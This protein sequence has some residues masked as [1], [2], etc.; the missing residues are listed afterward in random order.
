VDTQ[1][2]DDLQTAISSLTACHEELLSQDLAQWLPQAALAFIGFPLILNI[3]NIN[4]SSPP[5][6][7]AHDDSC[8]SLYRRTSVFIHF[9][10]V[11]CAKYE[12]VDWFGDIVR[13]IANLA[14]LG[15]FTIQR[16]KPSI[17]WKDV[18]ACQPRS[19]LR[20]VMVLDLGLVK[21]RLPRDTDFPVELRGLFSVDLNAP[22]GL[23]GSCCSIHDVP[24]Q[25]VPSND[26]SLDSAQVSFTMPDSCHIDTREIDAT[27]DPS[28]ET[29]TETDPAR[30]HET[31]TLGDECSL[32]QPLMTPLNAFEPTCSDLQSLGLFS[33][34]LGKAS[35]G[36]GT[37]GSDCQIWES[38]LE[39]SRSSVDQAVVD[40]MFD[41]LMF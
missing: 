22:R 9:M 14:R 20:L 38:G 34:N 40:R 39:T 1:T 2:Q 19:Y 18:L 25:T 10:E 27:L 5:M 3:L 17:T 12:G 21:S 8:V 11:Y 4:L 28:D 35:A 41:A 13:H 29:E 24:G 7:A 37:F 23:I 15:A 30:V 31:I 26:S 36:A 33:A 6:E 32:A 16:N